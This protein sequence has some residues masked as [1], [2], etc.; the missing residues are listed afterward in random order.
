MLRESDHAGSEIS[1]ILLQ[2][3]AEEKGFKTARRAVARKMLTI[4]WYMLT[5]EEPYRNN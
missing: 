5:N 4:M 2:N 3:Q 1:G